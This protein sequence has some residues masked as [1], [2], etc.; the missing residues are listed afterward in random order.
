[1]LPLAWPKKERQ[2]P[3]N[4]HRFITFTFLKISIYTVLAGQYGIGQAALY[5][6]LI[7]LTRDPRLSLHLFNLAIMKFIVA[8]SRGIPVLIFLLFTFVSIAQSFS[9]SGKVTSATGD[10]L[11]GVTVQAKNSRAS[12][13]TKSDGTFQ[14]NAP[15]ASA[16]FTFPFF[17]YE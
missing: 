12:A 5:L 9:V 8:L 17:G 10:P 4:K 7:V 15:S 6:F 16:V 11:T 13:T 3:D 1:L 2:N 14:I